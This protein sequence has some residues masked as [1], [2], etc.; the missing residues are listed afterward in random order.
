MYQCFLIMFF[1]V[2]CDGENSVEEQRR[3][4]VEGAE[5]F[6]GGGL[7]PCV[8]PADM[9]PV[10]HAPYGLMVISSAFSSDSS[11]VLQFLFR[12]R[13]CPVGMFLMSCFGW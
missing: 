5:S 11:S 1:Y 3:G 12:R 4:V 13:N 9:L 10:C 7:C 8:S 6:G 2:P